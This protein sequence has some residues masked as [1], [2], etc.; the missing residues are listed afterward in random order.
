MTAMYRN[1]KY[2]NIRLVKIRRCF[3]YVLANNKIGDVMNKAK[4]FIIVFLFG[5]IIYALIEV[6]ARGFT[7]WTMFITGGLVFYSLYLIFNYIGKGHLILKCAIGCAIIT[8]AEYLIGAI[9]NLKF[10][11]N[12]WDYSD[13]P[14]N[15][16][17]Q[18]CLLYSL[19]WFFLSIP[20]SFFAINIK[21]RIQ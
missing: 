16:F 21:K 11:M 19:G 1:Y 15:L 3:F 12:V 10:N 2:R 18:I 17:G 13:K 6:M 4:E 14:F 8:S 7:H 20:A 5:G 9:V